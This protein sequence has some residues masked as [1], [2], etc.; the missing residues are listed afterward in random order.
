MNS[1]YF[2]HSLLLIKRIGIAL[3]LFTLLR[4]TFLVFNY[5]Y[6]SAYDYRVFIGGIRFDIAAIAYTYLPFI[7]GSILPLKLRNK[8]SYQ[9]VLKALFLFSTVVCV[10]VS[11]IDMAYFPFTLKRTTADILDFVTTGDDTLRL[12]PQFLLDYWYL[13]IVFVAFLWLI[14]WT[15]NKTLSNF[16]PET[17]FWTQWL[18]FVLWLGIAVL[19]SRGGWQLRP[20]TSLQASQYSNVQN[21]PLVLNTPFTITR[22]LFK[23]Q[24]TEVNYFDDKELTQRFNPVQYYKADTNLRP[25][26]VLIILE[27]FSKEYIGGYHNGKGY[28]PFLDSLMEHSIVFDNAFANGKKS[29]EALP[30]ILAGLPSLMDSPYITSGYNNNSIQGIGTLLSEL[31]YSSSFYHGGTNGTMSFDAFAQ[32]SGIEKYYG[33][34]EYDNEADYDGNWGIFDEPYFQYFAKELSEKEEP[35]FSTIFSLS[36]HHPY[37][38]PDQHQGKFPKGILEVHESVGYSDHSL[39]RFFE[40]AQKMPWFE[41]TVFVI[42]ADHTAQS[43]RPKYLNRLGIFSVPLIIYNWKNGPSIGHYQP[44]T[45]HADISSICLEIANF[46]GK[47]LN[48]GNYPLDSTNQHFAVNYLTGVYQLIEEDYS[49]HFDGEKTIGLY[50]FPS[51]TTLVNNLMEIEN[52]QRD[53]MEKQLK[54]II[55]QYNHR[56]ITNELSLKK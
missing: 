54:A 36:S 38:I 30:S 15:Y 48:F 41:N 3:L 7:L 10:L 42:T 12:I 37:T 9:Q 19:S 32:M 2:H 16:V 1:L 31:N 4:I 51:D 5:A 33:R 53:K 22:T 21:V 11:V 29:I 35:F 14:N 23:A 8:R 17:K 26:I 25:N 34:K 39:K 43:I 13:G 46:D 28:T 24:I 18:L 40:T 52:K 55:Q 56:M 6:F 44:V 27:S 20:I 49:L 45:Q 50:H 47:A